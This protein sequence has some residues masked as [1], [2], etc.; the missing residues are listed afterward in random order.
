MAMHLFNAHAGP[1]A[2]AGVLMLGIIT[3]TGYVLTGELAIPIGLHIT[4]N[5]F[6]D[7]VFGFS[8]SGGD[9]SAATFVVTDVQGPALWI[10]DE[11]GPESGLLAI[12]AMVLGIVLIGLW[13]RLR[14]GYIS[15]RTT[16]ASVPGPA[17]ERVR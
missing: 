12:G 10:G 1:L 15:L 3:A 11:F 8:V 13:V 17:A 9:I 7:A 2:M 16:I 5:F 14:R 6:Q 4:W